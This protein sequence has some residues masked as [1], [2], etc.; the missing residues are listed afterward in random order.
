MTRRSRQVQSPGVF[1]DVLRFLALALAGW[2]L[3]VGSVPSAE[4][5]PTTLRSV[6]FVDPL[7][8][9]AFVVAYG[10]RGK[11]SLGEEVLTF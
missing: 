10:P 4:Q 11:S 3:M 2:T 5:S 7:E 8:G 6:P 1:Q 9:K